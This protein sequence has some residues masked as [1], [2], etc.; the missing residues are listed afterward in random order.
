MNPVD[1]LFLALGSEDASLDDLY[2]FC[3]QLY[4]ENKEPEL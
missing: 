4:D 1:S 2:K 3:K